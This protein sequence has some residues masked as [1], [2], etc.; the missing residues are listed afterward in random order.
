MRSK[1]G[2]V[3]TRFA[4]LGRAI[5]EQLQVREAILDGEIVALDNEGRVSFWDLIRSQGTLAY[6]TF[7]LLWL[8]GRDL[9]GLPLTRRKQRLERLIP[10]AV[11]PIPALPALRRRGENSS[12]RHVGGISRGSWQ[13]GKL[14]PT[15][16]GRYGTR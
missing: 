10:A 9:R 2:N 1:R 7:D 11:G 14:I 16:S 6:A 8:N 3:F 13:S 5:C 15:K 4:E 12:R